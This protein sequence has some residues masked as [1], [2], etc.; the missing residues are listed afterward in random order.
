MGNRTEATILVLPNDDPY[1][2]IEFALSSSQVSVA[3][4]YLPGFINA[5]Y[6][7]LTVDRKQGTVGSTKVTVLGNF[8]CCFAEVKE[9]E[10]YTSCEAASKSFFPFFCFKNFSTMLV[11]SI[12]LLF[13]LPFSCF[14]FL[15]FVFSFFLCF[16][17]FFPPTLSLSLSLSLIPSF[18]FS[19][20]SSQTTEL[21][22]KLCKR[23]K[24]IAMD[25]MHL[26]VF[27]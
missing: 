13:S 6:A 3:E 25:H 27:W 7:N 8:D 16:L 23:A 2:V 4:D 17:S 19:F 24:E 10:C 11:F 22:A 14:R 5:T 21:P 9:E 12:F 18:P 15:P 1:G 20:S 26:Q